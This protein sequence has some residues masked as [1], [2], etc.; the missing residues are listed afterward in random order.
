MKFIVDHDFHIHSHLSYC[1]K[2]PEQ[3]IINILKIA[4]E[5]GLRDICITDHFWDAEEIP[6]WNGD[7]WYAAQNFSYISQDLPYPQS[8]SVRIHFGCETELDC[9]FQV[10]ISPKH[11]DAFDFMI[12]PTTHMHSHTAVKDEDFDSLP[13]R[14]DLYLERL[15]KV[16]DQ[17]LPFEKIG[18]AHLTCAFMA[19]LDEDN[20]KNTFKMLDGITD[21][22]FRQVFKKFAK[23]GPGLELNFRLAEYQPGGEQDCIL[24]PYRIAKEC[25]AKFYFGTDAHFLRDFEGQT[26]NHEAIVEA[27]SLEETDKFRP[28]W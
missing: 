12:I 14:R 7:W 10:G 25:G 17:P 28:K 21:Q 3:N 16:L 20:W 26:E 19:G 22:E 1:S 15:H 8:D 5:R 9:Y 23:K 2:D 18:I 27:L 11:Y 6:L 24:R 13:R 4:E